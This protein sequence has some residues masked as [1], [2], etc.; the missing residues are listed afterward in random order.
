MENPDP[1]KIK[2]CQLLGCGEVACRVSIAPSVAAGHGH[3]HLGIMRL[4]RGPGSARRPR[5]GQV[6]RPPV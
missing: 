5:Q 1:S 2:L 4:P 3:D 6:Q